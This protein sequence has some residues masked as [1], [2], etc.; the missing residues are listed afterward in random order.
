[1]EG[2]LARSSG[3]SELD[4]FPRQAPGDAGAAAPS[5]FPLSHGRS[6]RFAFVFTITTAGTTAGRITDRRRPDP[7]ATSKFGNSAEAE[8]RSRR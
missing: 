4:L 7:A 6:E 8:N 5:V 3:G 2:K 1:M